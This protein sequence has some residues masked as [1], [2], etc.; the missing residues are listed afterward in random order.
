MMRWWLNKLQRR[1]GSI[2]R[3]ACLHA[4]VSEDDEAHARLRT[5]GVFASDL[6]SCSDFRVQCSRAGLRTVFRNGRFLI[7]SSHVRQSP[8]WHISLR[9]RCSCSRRDTRA[10]RLWLATLPTAY[11]DCLFLPRSP[12]CSCPSSGHAGTGRRVWPSNQERWL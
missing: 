4:C 5:P 1:Q 11:Y 6:S 2:K 12:A 9:H 10:G 8:V 7:G 3:I